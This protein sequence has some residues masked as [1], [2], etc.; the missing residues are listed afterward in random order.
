M[1]KARELGQLIQKG[2]RLA[3]ADHGTVVSWAALGL[4]ASCLSFC[5][6]PLLAAL[7]FFGMAMRAAVGAPVRPLRNTLSAG[8]VVLVMLASPVS[9]F[10]LSA[11]IAPPEVLGEAKS[12]I[13]LLV[14][15]ATFGAISAPFVT[16]GAQLVRRGLGV[17]DALGRA[18][19]AAALRGR[20]M[21]VLR[22]LILG[23]PIVL[24][25]SVAVRQSYGW[26]VVLV[27]GP[28]VTAF[29][30]GFAAACAIEDDTVLSNAREPLVR[31]WLW[32]PPALGLGLFAVALGAA[33]LTPAPAWMLAPAAEPAWTCAPSLDASGPHGLSITPTS[34]HRRFE[35]RTADGG[36]AGSITSGPRMVAVEVCSTEGRHWL[37]FIGLERPPR[38]ALVDERG[39]RLDD[40]FSERFASRMGWWIAL[41][42]GMGLLALFLFSLRMGQTLAHLGALSDAGADS[43]PGARPG[44]ASRIRSLPG[45]LS[46][47]QGGS[48]TRDGTSASTRGE[49]R[50]VSDDGAH[51]FVLP[52]RVRLLSAIA[53]SAVDRF[54][55]RTPLVLLAAESIASLGPR[56]GASEWPASAMLLH[57][58]AEGARAALDATLARSVAP[59]VALST[60]AFGVAALALF[61]QL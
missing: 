20:T 41:F 48:F 59:W 14:L 38:Y 39:V 6:V 28:L 29:A 45:K 56:A 15:V 57:G 32:F 61:F 22:G 21:M 1:S 58:E 40:G 17:T 37:R 3:G 42:A 36:G 34:D 23:L 13:V 44:A 27:L 8:V 9:A 35:V 54:P 55:D 26:L 31:T 7:G 52:R 18:L 25:L 46:V 16:T 24:L 60:L 5:L 11:S 50:F 49:V 4:L 10:L 12:F 47:G 43:G 53:S 51:V 30:V 2:V 19:A 33:V